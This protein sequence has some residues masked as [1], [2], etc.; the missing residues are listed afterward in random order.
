VDQAEDK[1]EGEGNIVVDR[2][3]DASV[4]KGTDDEGGDSR[5]L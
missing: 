1:S 2:P 3:V 5:A 4:D